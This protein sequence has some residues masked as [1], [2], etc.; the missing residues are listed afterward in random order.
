LSR[1]DTQC[2]L[3]LP[4]ESGG[5]GVSLLYGITPFW[6]KYIYSKFYLHLQFSKDNLLDL[7]TLA[8]L[9]SVS[10]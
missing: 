3:G 1:N 5:G 6:D 7:V 8:T 10:K 9:D 4:Q 2:L